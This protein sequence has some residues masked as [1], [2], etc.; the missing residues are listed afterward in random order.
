MFDDAP[1]IF[2][3][4]LT[5]HLMND[6]VM[7]PSSKSVVD[8]ATIEIHLLSNQNDPFDRSYLTKDMLVP[9]EELRNKILNYRQ[10]KQNT[11]LI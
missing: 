4:A 8:R 7:L 3:D 6:P 11:N 9:M 2:L 5:S 10:T 1:D